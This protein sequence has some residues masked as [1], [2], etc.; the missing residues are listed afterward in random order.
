MQF[1][2][3]CT[4]K[5]TQGLVYVSQKSRFSP[6]QHIYVRPVEMDTMAEIKALPSNH[7]QY[8]A[9]KAKGWLNLNKEERQMYQTQKLLEA[10]LIEPLQ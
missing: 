10:Q 2:A 5:Q 4:D 6:A 9:L 7:D 3:Y 8:M 1:P